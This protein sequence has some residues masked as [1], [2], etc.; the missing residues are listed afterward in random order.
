MPQLPDL[1]CPTGRSC[2]CRG[3]WLRW[4]DLA[5]HALKL[6]PSLRQMSLRSL[7]A[8]WRQRQR[9][10]VTLEEGSIG[11][12][13][14]SV[15]R[16]PGRT[17][18]ARFT[19]PTPLRRRASRGPPRRVLTHCRAPRASLAR[20]GPQEAR[21]PE[22]LPEQQARQERGG[23]RLR[24]RYQAR[25]GRGRRPHARGQKAVSQRRRHGPQEESN[26]R[27]PG[28]TRCRPRPS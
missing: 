26:L 6:M 23:Q 28:R 5:A 10:P 17:E 8:T 1:P 9:Q 20:D 27:P 21:R 2:R 16:R 25:H 19:A 24:Q 4:G 18:A 13:S 14:R 12:E 15:S 22:Q 7:P 11:R 3:R